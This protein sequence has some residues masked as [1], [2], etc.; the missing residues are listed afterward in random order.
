VPGLRAGAERVSRHWSNSARSV[1]RPRPRLE[2]SEWADTSRVIPQGTSPEPGRWRTSRTPYL[3]DPMDAISDPRTE[4]VYC[5]FCSQVGKTE[6]ELNVLGYHIDQDPA[7]LL[8]VL[9]TVE[10]AE[11]FSKERIEPMLRASPG[12][13]G[14]VTSGKAGRG[15]SRKSSETIREKHFSSGAFLA[16]VGANAPSGLASRPI[17]VVLCDEIDRFPPSAG[18]EG[19][20][21]EL[22]IQRTT[23]YP[24]RK[25]VLV[26][27]PTTDGKSP[28]QSWANEG[29]QERYWVPC[30]HCG[31][32]QVLR[33]GEK[34]GDGGLK[35]E[36]NDDGEIVPGSVFYECEHCGAVLTDADKPAMLAGGEWRADNPEAGPAVRSFVGL[37][38]IYSPWVRLE[39]VAKRWVKAVRSG[40]SGDPEKLKTAV[41]LLWGEEW[42]EHQG[43]LDVEQ[44]DGNR[45]PYG[46]HLPP[47]VR[48]LTCG[49][50][51][52]EDRL[53]A[54]V[55]G[56]GIG[57]ESW[58]VQYV[59]IYGSPT[60][61]GHQGPWAS[62]DALVG[63]TWRT[64]DGR[65]LQIAT[66]CVD[67]GGHHTDEVYRYCSARE[68]RRVWAVKGSS[69]HAAPLLK[70]PTSKQRHRKTGT[71]AWLF[72]AGTQTAKDTIFGRLQVEHPGPGY[73]HFPRDEH[74]GAAA[75]YDGDYFEALLGERRVTRIRS[76]Q[77]VDTW[78]QIPGRRNEALDCRVYAWAA[79]EIFDPSG[80]I[81][82]APQ[83]SQGDG[84]EKNPPQ[85]RTRK[86]AIRQRSR[87]IR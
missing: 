54:E 47:G 73:S 86:R 43:A 20:P 76:G 52:Q 17:R 66:T 80:A 25:I 87:G 5:K 75:G 12:L 6:F 65:T 59:R 28:I 10:A 85:S 24:N 36:T 38:A 23:N 67:S 62:L 33:N 46:E 3:R 39:T 58:G 22:A 2:V 11:A 18:T 13:R 42:I 56:W 27:T 70:R 53:E 84:P 61:L 68:A 44:L 15:S 1:L 26:S 4:R 55:V 48:V 8:Y 51:V 82:A 83:R 81:T 78:E 40:R 69:Q 64:Q 71:T 29:T 79:L 77:R 7:S 32:H 50:D 16:L 21:V 34:G 72:L 31:E 60:D 14:H 9:P 63:Q 35:W 19:D 41:N 45:H 57:G 30:P 74:G 37:N 49:V